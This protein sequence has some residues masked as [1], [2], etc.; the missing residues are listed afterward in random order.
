MRAFSKYDN[1]ITLTKIDKYTLYS[2]ALNVS[3][4][5]EHGL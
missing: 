3:Y 2:Y 1:N 5:Q 4:I